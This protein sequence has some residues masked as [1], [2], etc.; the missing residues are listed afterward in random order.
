V[1]LKGSRSVVALPDGRTFINLTGNPGM[2]TGGAGDVLTGTI[3]GLLAQTKDATSATLLGVYLH[4]LAGDLA[5]AT[6]S[7][8]GALSILA[9]ISSLY[10]VTTIAL[11][12][13]LTGARPTRIQLT[14]ITLALLG[15]TLLST[16]H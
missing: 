9:A 5:Y 6:A 7:G 10:P 14:G 4:G 12:L 8:H 15:A 16:T 3:S 13:L 1:V 11:A 2:A